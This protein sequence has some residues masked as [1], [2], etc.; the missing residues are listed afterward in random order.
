MFPNPVRR[1]LFGDFRAEL[2]VCLDSLHLL[3]ARTAFFDECLSCF[4][5]QMMRPLDITI[6]RAAYNAIPNAIPDLS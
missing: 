5:V 4:R 1:I 2:E 3:N 6:V